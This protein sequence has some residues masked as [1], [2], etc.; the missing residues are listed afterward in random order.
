M[1]KFNKEI[2]FLHLPTNQIY[3]INSVREY[4][5]GNNKLYLVNEN[6]YNDEV[7]I[8]LNDL[9]KSEEWKIKL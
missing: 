5:D 8:Y 2:K 1:K 4:I 3:I 7:A 6:N 9:Q